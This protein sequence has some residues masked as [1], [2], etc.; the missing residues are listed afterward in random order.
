VPNYL[1]TQRQYSEGHEIAIHTW[2]HNDLATMSGEQVFAELAWCLYAIHAAIGQTPKLFRPPFGSINNVVRQA[3]AQLGLTV[4]ALN[5]KLLI[6]GCPMEP[7]FERLAD[8]HASILIP[9]CH[10]HRGG[11]HSIRRRSDPP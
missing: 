7:G 3:A 2:S 11:I 4:L 1:L 9:K 6:E 10:Q 8:P 5:N